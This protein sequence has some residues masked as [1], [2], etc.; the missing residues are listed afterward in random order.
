MAKVTGKTIERDP[1]I[2]KLADYQNQQ[3]ASKAERS[4]EPIMGEEVP[5]TLSTVKLK[6][7][8]L[9]TYRDRYDDDNT[10]VTYDPETDTVQ[11]TT[12]LT[13]HEAPE[14]VRDEFGTCTPEGTVEIYTGHEAPDPLP[15]NA[16]KA[17]PTTTEPG[18]AYEERPEAE[19]VFQR[20]Q[21]IRARTR[22]PQ[23]HPLTS[24]INKYNNVREARGQYDRNVKEARQS[25][26]EKIKQAR[27][28]YKTRM[29]E[30]RQ[31]RGKEGVQ[32]IRECKRRYREA[33]QRIQGEYRDDIAGIRVA[34]RESV[35]V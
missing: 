3:K 8:R 1:L 32:A 6:H 35:T 24:P 17:E 14:W 26:W 27:A 2:E 20:D 28:E 33:T 25:R 16:D 12:V 9:E 31:L 34:Y 30:I 11:I 7:D 15:P 21:V 18:D 5:K 10:T 13:G 22:S 4:D 23:D 19:I 29:R